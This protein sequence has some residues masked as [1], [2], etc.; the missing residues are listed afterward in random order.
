MGVTE[1]G[2]FQHERLYLENALC[3]TQ[4]YTFE[5]TVLALEK[6]RE[7]T[8][9]MYSRSRDR[10]NLDEAVVSIV[11]IVMIWFGYIMVA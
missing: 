2:R 1:Q 8:I 5:Q 11:S 7:R 3:T 6:R 10:N 4:K 9:I